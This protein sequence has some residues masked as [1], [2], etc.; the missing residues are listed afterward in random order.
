MLL[1]RLAGRHLWRWLLPMMGACGSS[2]GQVQRWHWPM[3]S[4]SVSTS[5]HGLKLQAKSVQPLF[6]FKH[7]LILSWVY[8]P[9]KNIQNHRVEMRFGH[10]C[11]YICSCSRTCA[12]E[13]RW[14]QDP[15]VPREAGRFEGCHDAG[16]SHVFSDERAR[17]DRGEAHRSLFAGQSEGLTL[18]QTYPKLAMANFNMLIYYFCLF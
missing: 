13:H 8:T 6:F 2:T 12:L 1:L 7:G 11:S 3:A 5:D 4:C 10:P 15:R 18:P 17:S 9:L 14:R 16:R